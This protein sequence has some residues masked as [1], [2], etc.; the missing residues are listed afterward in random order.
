M[1][2][3][4][5]SKSTVSLHQTSGELETSIRNLEEKIN[6]CNVELARLKT[7]LCGS[8][9]A[10]ALSAAKRKATT[11]LRRRQVYE[12]QRDQLL[13]AQL[14]VDN[15][16]HI[17][18][19]VQTAAQ[20]HNA[21]SASLKATKKQLKKTNFDDLERLQEDMEDLQDYTEDINDALIRPDLVGS[22]I[23][24]AEL[25]FELSTL[26]EQD[27][28]VPPVSASRV[29]SVKT[30]IAKATE[31]FEDMIAPTPPTSRGTKIKDID[32]NIKN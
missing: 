32:S 3:F 26:A 25:E 24:D 30:A 28:E 29:T 10:T 16:N 14:A 21:L 4:G 31:F 6:S 20:I 7:V 18:S 11:I 17:Y 12:T 2:F 27:V 5:K 22:Q 8:S 19:Q 15:C 23:D 9:N 1:R 13:G